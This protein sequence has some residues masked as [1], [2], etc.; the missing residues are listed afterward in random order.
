MQH[1]MTLERLRE[2]LKK[3]SIRRIANACGMSSATI[4]AVRSGNIENCNKSTIS[5]LIQYVEDNNL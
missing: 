1:K 5:I 4:Q 3:H 2:G